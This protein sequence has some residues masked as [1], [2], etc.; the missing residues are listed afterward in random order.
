MTLPKDFT[1]GGGQDGAEGGYVISFSSSKRNFIENFAKQLA[2]AVIERIDERFPLADIAI[3]FDIFDRRRFPAAAATAVR[4]NLSAKPVASRS[5]DDKAELKV[6][7][8]V[9]L[10]AVLET[11]FFGWHVTGTRRLW[12]Q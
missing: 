9:C 1:Y 2:T 11:H 8:R 12:S 5:D 6:S 7:S 3:A 4:K 10:T